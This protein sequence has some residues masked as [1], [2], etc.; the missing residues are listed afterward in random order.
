VLFENATN[1]GDP[2]VQVILKHLPASTL[3]R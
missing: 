1:P 2:R 3:A